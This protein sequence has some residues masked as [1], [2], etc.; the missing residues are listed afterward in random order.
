MFFVVSLCLTCSLTGSTLVAPAVRAALWREV[1][2]TPGRNSQNTCVSYHC[3][4]YSMHLAVSRPGN[5]LCPYMLHTARGLACKPGTLLNVI[6]R[7]LLKALPLHV[8]HSQR[9]GVRAWHS[10]ACWGSTLQR[11]CPCPEAVT[12]SQ[13]PGVSLVLCCMLGQNLT[14]VLPLP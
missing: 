12:H 10:A 14:K 8:T 3:R 7:T 11:F 2:M 13:R 9:P 1:R 5:G 4:L 6:G